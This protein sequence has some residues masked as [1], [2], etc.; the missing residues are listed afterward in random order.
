MTS[1]MMDDGNDTSDEQPY[2]SD[3][4]GVDSYYTTTSEDISPA[5]VATSTGNYYDDS[6]VVTYSSFDGMVDAANSMFHAWNPYKPAYT[7]ST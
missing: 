2:T 3:L 7:P 1:S 6:S 4:P 5:D